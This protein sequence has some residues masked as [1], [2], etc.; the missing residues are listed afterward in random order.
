MVSLVYYISGHGFGH[1]VRSLEVMRRLGELS[2]EIQ[3]HVKTSAPDWLFRR[4][5]ISV[6][7]H[8]SLMD[9]GTVQTNSLEIN[10]KAT[11]QAC[12]ALQTKIPD[13]VDQEL[14]FIQKEDIKLILGDIPPLC[15][16]IAR[17]ASVPAVAITNFTWDWIYQGYVAE[18]PSFLPIIQNMETHYEKATLCLSLPF[19]SNL[20]VFSRKISIPLIARIS[21]RDQREARKAL[22]LPVGATVVLLS[23]G[24]FGLELAH[25]LL[26]NLKDFFFVTTGSIPKKENN[27]WVLPEAQ[28]HYEDLVRA[29]DAVVSKPGYGIV[30]DIIAHRVPLLYTSRGP[31]AEYPLLVETLQ[32]WATSEF[33]PAKDLTAGNLKPY[34]ERLLAKD[35][36]WPSVALN[37]AEVAAKE[38]LKLL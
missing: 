18:Y 20:H 19:S 34:L 28:S 21:Q 12:R 16:E 1:S 36:H 5:P 26:R 2:P 15:F 27:L 13:I 4:I 38:I 14:E 35:N 3:I 25:E 32:H 7:Y 33:I 24:G 10:V 9:I 8:A 6:D 31:F 23:F 22:N 17:K 37:G 11:L 29:S 30:A